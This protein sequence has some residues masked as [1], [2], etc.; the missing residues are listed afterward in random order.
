MPPVC[1]FLQLCVGG[2]LCFGLC[3]Q[4]VDS[5]N[6]FCDF[7][8]CRKRVL[9]VG[10]V[11]CAAQRT[12]LAVLKVCTVFGQ[13]GD[14]LNVAQFFIQQV[15]FEPVFSQRMTCQ[16]LFQHAFPLCKRLVGAGLFLTDC[17]GFFP[18]FSK[19]GFRLCQCLSR[20]F[21]RG[22]FLRGVLCHRMQVSGLFFDGG[23]AGGQRFILRIFNE[24]TVD[25]GQCPVVL[26][27]VL[28]LFGQHFPVNVGVRFFLTVLRVDVGKLFLQSVQC[29]VECA[30]L[31]P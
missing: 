17:F 3:N 28:C 22:G 25:I 1:R 14:E 20:L 2:L 7:V 5:G 26:G 23:Q 13:R 11:Q 9:C 10:V 31:L 15:F 19:V 18:A 21:L 27:K 6:F 30:D 4:P 29:L 8:R 16:Y 12:G 24:V